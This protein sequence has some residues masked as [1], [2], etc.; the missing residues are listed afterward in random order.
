V[1][2]A[3]HATRLGH[4]VRVSSRNSVFRDTPGRVIAFDEVTG[5][6]TVREATAEA[7]AATQAKYV[8]KP[9]LSCRSNAAGAEAGAAAAVSGD[10]AAAAAAAAE[11]LR[12]ALTLEILEHLEFQEHMPTFM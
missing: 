5:V 9:D 8:N 11:P 3:A 10:D 2:A 1:A 6:V 4:L 12:N 7:Y